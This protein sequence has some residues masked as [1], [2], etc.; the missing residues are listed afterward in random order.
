[1]ESTP[2]VRIPQSPAPRV[3]QCVSWSGVVHEGAQVA[4]AIER[5]W[6]SPS[7]ITL[8]TVTVHCHEY[9]AEGATTECP[10]FIHRYGAEGAAIHRSWDCLHCSATVKNGTCGQQNR[11]FVL[12]FCAVKAQAFGLCGITVDHWQVALEKKRGLAPKHGAK[13]KWPN[14]NVPSF[15]VRVP[16]TNTTHAIPGLT[17]THTFTAC[18]QYSSHFPLRSHRMRTFAMQFTASRPSPPA[19]S[20]ADMGGSRNADGL[21]WR[22]PSLACDITAR[23]SCN[24]RWSRVLQLDLV[25]GGGG[26]AVMNMVRG[27]WQNGS[28]GQ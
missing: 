15:M 22:G 20:R 14:K 28:S 11:K 17:Q 19:Q 2:P 3:M 26:A 16:H 23:R 18:C 1:M 6:S 9:G 4:L 27:D 21:F 8:A 5:R 10:E 24:A 13:Q 7:G 12:L 25:G